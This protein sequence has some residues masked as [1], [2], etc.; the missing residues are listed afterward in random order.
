MGGPGKMPSAQNPTG[1]NGFPMASYRGHLAFSSLLGVG[2]GALGMWSGQFDW[3]PAV[4]AAGVTT[5][6]GL[7]PDLDS[8]SGV[9]VRELF[10]IAAFL[11]PLLMYGRLAQEKLTV[12][13]TV[14][15]L[16]GVYLFVR[17]GLS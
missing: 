12:E 4:L 1:R 6:G 11:A 15:L 16:A 2:Y 7:L 8:D 14:V 3:G 13:Q 10:G 5:L 9:P 17:Y